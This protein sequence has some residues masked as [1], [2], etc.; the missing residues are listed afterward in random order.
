MVRGTG[1]TS[2]YFMLS[3]ILLVRYVTTQEERS[4]R[5]RGGA[6]IS[7]EWE[8]KAVTRCRTKFSSSWQMVGADNIELGPH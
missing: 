6:V 1:E 3:L 8:T 5:G 2:F 4:R 7:T